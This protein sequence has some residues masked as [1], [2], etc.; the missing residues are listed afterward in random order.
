MAMVMTA[1]WLD[2]SAMAMTMATAMV[3]DVATPR[4][5]TQTHTSR[6]LVQI[7]EEDSNT[8]LLTKQI[9]KFKD[10]KPRRRYRPCL[11]L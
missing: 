10:F 9:L 1:Q 11:C 7:R 8:I 3:I 4:L 2:T 6:P 5:E